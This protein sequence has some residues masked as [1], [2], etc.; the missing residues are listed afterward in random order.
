MITS[1]DYN[2]H[3]HTIFKVMG[4]L[5]KIASVMFSSFECE[6]MEHLLFLCDYILLSSCVYIKTN[7]YCSC[8]FSEEKEVAQIIGKQE[9][10]KLI[11]HIV[12]LIWLIHSVQPL[13]SLWL[14]DY[15]LHGWLGVKN[16][17]SMMPNHQQLETCTSAN[18]VIEEQAV[19]RL[20][21]FV[22]YSFI[23]CYK[24]WYQP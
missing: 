5:K 14:Y 18:M 11:L 17:V 2:V 16:Q 13:H 19:N 3:F 24:V 8:L 20:H 7:L 15:E 4:G 22:S 12:S 9:E 1:I 10:E 6:S 23:D 21:I